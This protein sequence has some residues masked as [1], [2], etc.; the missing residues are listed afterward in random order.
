MF[1]LLYHRSGSFHTETN[2]RRHFFLCNIFAIRLICEIFFNGLT[3]TIR[4]SVC[5]IPSV[6]STTRYRKNQVSFA[7]TL[8][9]SG[10]AFDR[11]F[12]LEGV[13]MHALLFVGHHQVLIVSSPLHY[14]G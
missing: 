1:C 11:T 6:W 8:W 5:T 12:I 4:M 3:V 2:S 9:M 7:V 10:V 14:V 13:D